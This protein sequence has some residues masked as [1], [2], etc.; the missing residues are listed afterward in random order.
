[1][2]NILERHNI[3]YYLGILFLVVLMTSVNAECA[4]AA[5][6]NADRIAKRNTLSGGIFEEDAAGIRYRKADQ[7]YAE[8][9]WARIE[10]NIYYFDREEKSL[11]NNN[12]DITSV[13]S[14]DTVNNNSNESIYKN[15]VQR[16]QRAVCDYYKISIEQMKGKNRNNS[17][18]VNI[19]SASAINRSNV[20]YATKDIYSGAFSNKIAPNALRQEQFQEILNANNAFD[21]SSYVK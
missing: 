15:D 21:I 11:S 13:N 5:D 8:G 18:D 17:V 9:S 7:T 1:M 19:Y 16:I 12:K 20:Y 4:G 6:Q 14:N 2:K 3:L 10:G